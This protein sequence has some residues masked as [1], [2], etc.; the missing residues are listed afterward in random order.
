MLSVSQGP[1][2]FRSICNPQFLHNK[3][4]VTPGYVVLVANGSLV[5]LNKRANQ[6]LPNTR[7]PNRPTMLCDHS[8]LFFWSKMAT[9]MGFLRVFAFLVLAPLI[10]IADGNDRHVKFEYKFS[11]KGPHLV[12][13][14]GSIP[15]W[16][17]G[18]SKWI[19]VVRQQ[20]CPRK[21]SAPTWMVQFI[22]YSN[23]LMICFL[24]AR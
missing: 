14:D 5:L 1:F 6:R 12:N 8:H 22:F 9:A 11:F 18:G 21:Y 3:N 23:V 7:K 2:W 17:H 10:M 16:S 15:F 20:C 13:K 4:C 19:H 24:Q